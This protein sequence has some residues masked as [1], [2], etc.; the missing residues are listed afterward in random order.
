[1][2]YEPDMTETA[3]TVQ[4]GG[5]VIKRHM[6]LLFHPDKSP[7]SRTI[8]P[9]GTPPLRQYESVFADMANAIIFVEKFFGLAYV[10]WSGFAP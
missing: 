1:M 5:R 9:P 7:Y 10:S 2:L 8:V 6:R 3:K 4:D